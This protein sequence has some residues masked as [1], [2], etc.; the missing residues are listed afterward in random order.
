MGISASRTLSWGI[1]LV[2][3]FIL[4]L[5][6]S[7]FAQ[8]SQAQDEGQVQ[9]LAGQIDPG[10]VF[11]YRLPS[12]L[13]GQML[14][15]RMETASG[16]LDPQIALIAPGIDPNLLEAEAESALDQAVAM[17][18]DPLE[19]LDE[20]RD[21][22]T[23]AWDDDGGGGLAAALEYQI[24]A[25]G[26]YRLLVSGALSYLGEKTSGDYRLFIGLD[27]P[28]VLSG[29]GEPTGDTIAVLDAEATP[30]GV[31][32]QQITG[33][34]TPEKPWTF[35]R[36]HDLK[37]GDTLYVT[38][39]AV[40]GDLRPSIVLQNYA[41]KPIRTGNLDG[42]DTAASLEYTFPQGGRN[43][44][45]EI[46][47]CCGD[48]P[49]SGEYRLTVGVNA[50]E[51]LSGEAK[52]D[53]RQMVRHPIDVKTGI[54]LE[55]IIDVDHDDE[56]FTAQ[57]SIQMDWTD[58]ALA[59][60]SDDC[61]CQVKTF[62]GNTF[63]DFVKAVEGRWPEF[64]FQNQQG[65]RWAQNKV[66]LIWSDGRARYFERFTTNFQVDFDFRPYPFDTQEFVIR[67]D[68][69]FPEEFLTF[70]DLVGFSEI[71]TEHGEDEFVITDFETSVSSIPGSDQSS[72]S[73]FTFSFSA[74]RHSSYYTLQIFLPILLIIGVSWITFF[75]RDYG[76]RIEVASANLLLFIAFSFSLADNY[77]RLGYLTFLDYVMAAMFVVN[78][79]VVAYNVWLKRMEIGG[80]VDKADRIDRVM[81]WLYPFAYVLLLGFGVWLFL[82]QGGQPFIRF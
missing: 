6:L 7:L 17:G 72:N 81:D 39:E 36:L 54:K 24:P 10:E 65:N 18:L 33:S 66:A 44:R 80:D 82:I 75:L 5:S 43:H 42:R 67:V 32:V 14:Y 78:A 21:Q 59:F 73:R 53:G 48:Q 3:N 16:N 45:L 9:F 51:V 63:D 25:D 23:L 64:T 29:E 69:L 30:P 15:V 35:A 12:L 47:G 20:F 26:D 27:A 58:P 8:P 68:S 46:W 70:S 50:P 34:L 31:G 22:F 57:A 37:P 61:Q 55:Q 56:F 2:L 28:Q 1:G 71:S 76:R 11:L 52:P 38:I 4:L 49:T 62:T 13:A 74:P 79:F 19:A 40:S 41:L 77:P 60:N